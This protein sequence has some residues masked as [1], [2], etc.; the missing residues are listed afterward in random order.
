MHKLSYIIK[1]KASA[2][3]QFADE[4]DNDILIQVVDDAGQLRKIP[5]ILTDLKAR[6]GDVLGCSYRL[7]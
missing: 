3:Q 2:V 7:M 6:Y 4:G 1:T 5:V